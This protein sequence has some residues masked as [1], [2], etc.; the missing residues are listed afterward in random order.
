MTPRSSRG[1]A[2]NIAN[3][4]WLKD[5]Q[6]VVNRYMK[7]YRETVDFMYHDPKAIEIYSGWLNIT[8][9]KAKRTRDDFFK[10]P[11]IDP[12]KIVGLDQIMKDAVYLKFTAQPLTKEQ[13]ADL[14]RIPSR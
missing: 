5:R 2:R 10:W 3:A 8:P 12:D 13:P 1:S 14:I 4:N 11:A 6:D 9:A 7:A